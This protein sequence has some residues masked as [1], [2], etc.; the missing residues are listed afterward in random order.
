MALLLS[1]VMTLDSQTKVPV[2]YLF[3]YA[4]TER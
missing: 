3:I 4:Q 2:V 1:L